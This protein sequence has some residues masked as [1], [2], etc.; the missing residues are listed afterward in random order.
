MTIIEFNLYSKIK[1][2]E[3]LGKAWSKP[4]RSNLSPNVV[5]IT[6]NFNTVS[7]WVATSIVK[8]EG[9]RERANLIK[10]FIKM[11]LVIFN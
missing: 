10:K 2:V 11:A 1:P 8:E 4:D 9:V 7:M 3:L 6:K 5:A